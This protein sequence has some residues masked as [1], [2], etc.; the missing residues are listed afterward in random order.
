MSKGLR[1]SLKVLALMLVA[2]SFTGIAANGEVFGGD[3]VGGEVVDLYA[4]AAILEFCQRS[5]GARC[6][7]AKR[8]IE[9]VRPK[10]YFYAPEGI[11]SG[12]Q[13]LTIY[14]NGDEPYFP[15]VVV[16]FDKDGIIHVRSRGTFATPKQQ[17]LVDTF[18]KSGDYGNVVGIESV[19][20]EI[21]ELYAKAAMLELCQGSPGRGCESVKRKMERID[22]EKYF[23]TPDRY[24]SIQQILMIYPD[25][26]EPQSPFVILEFGKDGWLTVLTRGFFNNSFLQQL[27]DGFLESGNFAE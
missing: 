4:K 14:S 20:G 13:I 11:S 8:T 10:K 12:Q 17:H 16:S 3:S 6:D 22:P 18:L 26:N 5:P 23:F 27:I 24:F 19:D 2:W 7:S 21:V 1:S 9:R 25:D 15:Y